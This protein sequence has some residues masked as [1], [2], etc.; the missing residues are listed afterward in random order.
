METRSPRG[1]GNL[2]LGIS[3]AARGKKGDTAGP[4]G[5]GSPGDAP[6]P[7][8][9]LWLPDPGSK[10]SS[11]FPE[12]K[13]LG[14]KSSGTRL[15]NS[16]PVVGNISYKAIR[17]TGQRPGPEARQT[18]PS[19]SG[20]KVGE[21]GGRRKRNAGL[22]GQRRAR[23][24][25]RSA[26]GGDR[27][28]RSHWRGVRA[29]PEGP[30]PRTAR[31]LSPP[32]LFPSG[33]GGALLFPA[34]PRE[35]PHLA[36]ASQ[37][38]LHC[39]PAWPSPSGR[40][41]DG[42]PRA[43]LRLAHPTPNYIFGL[44]K[45]P[46]HAGPHASTA[47]RTG[48]PRAA[49]SH[50]RRGARP[51]GAEGQGG[52]APQVLLAGTRQP[53]A[54]SPG[55]KKAAG[56]G[57][58]PPLTCLPPP[59]CAL[60]S[61]GSAEPGPG[62][63]PAPRAGSAAP[64]S[65]RPTGTPVM[66]LLRSL[67]NHKVRDDE[68]TATTPHTGAPEPTTRPG[69]S[70]RLHCPKQASSQ[71]T[72]SKL[73]LR[74]R[75]PGGAP[76]DPPAPAAARPPLPPEPRCPA[77]RPV[78][79]RNYHKAPFTPLRQAVKTPAAAALPDIAASL[80]GG[81]RRAATPRHPARPRPLR[82]APPAPPPRSPRAPRGARDTPPVMQPAPPV[83]PA[84][85]GFP[86]SRKGIPA[87]SGPAEG[88]QPSARGVEAP[89]A[90]PAS[91]AGGL[92][93]HCSPAP[94]GAF[95]GKREFCH[96]SAAGAASSPSRRRSVWE[97]LPA[98]RQAINA[99]S[100]DLRCQR[101]ALASQKSPDSLPLGCEVRITTS[102][103]AG[104]NRLA[105]VRL[106]AFFVPW[107]PELCSGR[108]ATPGEDIGASVRSSRGLP[109]PAARPAAFPS[110]GVA[111]PGPGRHPRPAP[112][113]TKRKPEH[114]GPSG[115][116]NETE[117]RWVLRSRDARGPP[118][119]ARRPDR[120]AREGQA[121]KHSHC[122]PAPSRGARPACRAREKRSPGPDRAR[123]GGRSADPPGL[124]AR[125]GPGLGKEGGSPAV[126]GGQ[127]GCELPPPP[128]P[129]A[130]HGHFVCLRRARVCVCVPVPRPRPVPSGCCGRCP[131]CRGRAV[132]A[133][134]PAGQAEVKGGQPRR[135]L[136]AERC[137]R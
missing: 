46:C 110:A 43:S 4:R 92:T 128:L 63:L 90:A 127:A 77:P 66:P 44:T 78:E 37:S 131:G 94:P 116:G 20:T 136:R 105:L 33:S 23:S 85:S 52:A 125:P 104:R 55:G 124:D 91:G 88:S 32:A 62:A 107:V 133:V 73:P 31:L 115:T 87:P 25:G 120:T 111:R 135:L 123:S 6:E 71:A 51:A 30:R 18:S 36:L 27:E 29:L 86:P 39:L 82:R 74:H 109:R 50:V 108:L 112:L 130:Y 47:P 102:F 56:S 99:D 79:N 64:C 21:S 45:L 98:K 76:L 9:A 84:G 134:G 26:G 103:V 17:W 68:N 11:E 83:T 16:L 95:P 12:R 126:R 24:R 22:G 3:T 137:S 34:A 117:G 8:G 58:S 70:P 7:E 69:A 122:R 5:A 114:A 38:S 93:A 61:A 42:K 15:V 97:R 54:G 65:P 35:P 53:A 132:P 121:D 10:R 101:P 57:I 106:C 19:I 59:D 2:H 100:L 67:P 129:L 28:R 80:R 48:K 81:S 14:T 119:P 40:P 96:L 72:A 49:L 41:F 75:S 13:L 118:A 1:P 89:G 113:I 60:L